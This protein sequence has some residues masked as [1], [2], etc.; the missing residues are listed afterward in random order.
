MITGVN[1]NRFHLLAAA[2][3]AAVQVV[4]GVAALY[5][6]FFHHLLIAFLALDICH[7]E[8]F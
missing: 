8:N 7:F 5:D 4:L 1:S 3:I 6:A 2:F